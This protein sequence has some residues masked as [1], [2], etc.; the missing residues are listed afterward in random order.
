M[1][2]LC[3]VLRRRIG[4]EI[5]SAPIRA[6]ACIAGAL[7]LWATGA[8][9]AAAAPKTRQQA[10]VLDAQSAD[11]GGDS[12]VFHKIKI[13]QGDMSIA[14][15]VGHG[16]STAQ[17]GTEKGGDRNNQNFN[18]DDSVWVFRG[19]VKI[20]TK[21]GQVG[22]DEAA[23]TFYRQ[24]LTKAIANGNPATFEGR[25]AKTGKSAHGHADT[26]D[27]D[28]VKNLVTL[29]DN[30]W[31]TDGQVEVRGESLRYN[32]LEQ[33]IAA[34]SSESG[35]QRVHIVMPPPPSKP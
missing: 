32:L 19:N 24:Q 2:D 11:Y 16:T 31:L 25:I 10:I 12:V 27:Y 21:E 5:K 15:E 23:I 6:G 30:A 8:I 14:A 33:S 17:A 22:S 34:D 35:S 4:E 20:T 1:K 18:F 13:T 29:I 28:A 3:L 9:P 26:I 7:V